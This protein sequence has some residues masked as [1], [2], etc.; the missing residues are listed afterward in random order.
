MLCGFL[1]QKLIFLNIVC[2]LY[3]TDLKEIKMYRWESS[4]DMQISAFFQCGGSPFAK[5]KNL[6]KNKSTLPSN[7]NHLIRP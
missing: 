2:D 4:A 5:N 1:L 7:F 6:K 3:E